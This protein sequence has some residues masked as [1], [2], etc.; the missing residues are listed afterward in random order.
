MP[1]DE[2]EMVQ[3]ILE[4]LTDG[5]SYSNCGQYVEGLYDYSVIQKNTS[6]IYTNLIQNINK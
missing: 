1:L 3:N 5:K 6:S 2:N 4:I